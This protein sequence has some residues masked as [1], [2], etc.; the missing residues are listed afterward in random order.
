[1]PAQERVRCDDGGEFFECR[2]ADGFGFDRQDSALI[3]IETQPLFAQAFAQGLN[4]SVLEV[5]DFLLFAVE[6]GGEKDD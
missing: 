3:V 4:L 5:D 1:M 2:I 6:R